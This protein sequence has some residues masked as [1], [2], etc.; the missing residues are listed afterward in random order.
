MNESNAPLN[1][2]F[3]NL[4]SSRAAQQQASYAERQAS[5]AKSALSSTH[6]ST[7]GAYQSE[8]SNNVDALAALVQDLNQQNHDLLG[9][10]SLLEGELD[11]YKRSNGS[12]GSTT[13]ADLG[14]DRDD[15]ESGPIQ[16]H[17]SH[18]LNQLEFAH[19]ASQR[20]S[21]RIESLSTELSSSE[22]RIAQLESENGELQRQFGDRGYRLNQ[23]EQ[24]CRDLRLRLQRQQQYTLQFK[25]ALEKCL[26]VPPPSYG[27]PHAPAA[28]SDFDEPIPMVPSM[29]EAPPQDA[30]D[31]SN[32][33]VQPLF[34]KVH[35]IRPWAA[36]ASDSAVQF[37]GADLAS[38]STTSDE[39]TTPS[40]EAWSDAN[41][42]GSESSLPS[43]AFP[44]SR[45]QATLQHLAQETQ[46]LE[47][48]GTVEPL[49]TN[50]TGEDQR[51]P[52]QQQ[53]N[54]YGEQVHPQPVMASASGHTSVAHADGD[55][56]DALLGEHQ[57]TIAQT[58]PQD[59]MAEPVGNENPYAAIAPQPPLYDIQSV[60]EVDK[61]PAIA[62]KPPS[63]SFATT[64]AAESIPSPSSDRE[65][66]EAIAP[67][68]VQEAASTPSISQD[69]DKLWQSLVNLI[70]MSAADGLNPT[71]GIGPK[72]TVAAQASNQ[73]E[74]PMMADPWAESVANS[75]PEIDATAPSTL[76]TSVFEKIQP[77]VAIATPM[78]QDVPQ[79]AKVAESKPSSAAA[80]HKKTAR[81][82]IDLPTFLAQPP[83]AKPNPA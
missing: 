59:L 82:T 24:E 80:S 7:S 6:S 69:D 53:T 72:E 16:E 39:L 40:N 3:P 14:G 54:G 22:A 10:I 56:I 83:M 78:K 79:T 4:V 76:Q 51:D 48:E 15:V 2:D 50:G 63:V 12:H 11:Q 60:Q 62:P 23:L 65:E 41:T 77:P 52:A 81:R 33:L 75:V 9:R 1:M 38:V 49:S 8:G 44:S 70:D 71:P 47:Q 29:D 58:T 42:V 21:I 35:H 5:L 73:A 20:Q 34:P 31:D 64:P 68:S 32:W 74:Q 66:T 17:V 18:L 55:P 46:A 37:E 19:Q 13:G 27:F 67:F 57:Q 25:A 43:L 61:E 36:N 30:E 45:F 28:L 26:E